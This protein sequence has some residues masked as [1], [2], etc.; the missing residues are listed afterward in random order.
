[1]ATKRQ[2]INAKIAELER[3]IYASNEEI[4]TLK[5]QLNDIPDGV[6]DQDI[7]AIAQAETERKNRILRERGYLPPK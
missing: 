3:V 4:S 6:L 7:E 1:M 5:A 2:Q